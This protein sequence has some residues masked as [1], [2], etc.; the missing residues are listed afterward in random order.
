MVFKTRFSL[1][2]G[3]F[4]LGF[5]L[6]IARLFYWQVMR[7]GELSVLAQKQYNFLYKAK[8]KRGNIYFSDKSPFV[9]NQPGFLL[10]ANPTKIE[11]K[12]K[13]SQLLSPI[14][15]QDEASISSILQNQLYW[16]AVKHKIDQETK[17]K[18]AAL[19]IKELGFA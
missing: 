5:L 8:A 13:L 4:I 17:E 10:Y 11:N 6:I 3:L 9:I 18:I 12:A 15:E 14:I 1:L 19:Q 2:L 16:V 7:G